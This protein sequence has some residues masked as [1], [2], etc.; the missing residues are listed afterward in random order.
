[1]RVWHENVPPDS[2]DVL[3]FDAAEAGEPDLG[4]IVENTALQA[5]LSAALRG[6]R[7]PHVAGNAAVPACR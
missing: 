4:C 2:P 5:A 6:A 1:M 7:Y 3:A